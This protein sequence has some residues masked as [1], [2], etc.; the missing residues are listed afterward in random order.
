MKNFLK[1]VR[2][3]RVLGIAAVVLAL[4]IPTA[5]GGSQVSP[6][7]VRR[8]NEAVAGVLSG[9]GSNPGTIAPGLAE[10]GSPGA[11]PTNSSG[12]PALPG[13]A[14]GA[15][16]TKPGAV[17]GTGSGSPPI[18]VPKGSCTGFKN[19]QGISDSTIKIGNSSDVSGPVPGLFKAAQQATKAYVAYFNSTSSICGR[20]LDLMNLDSRTDAGADQV[21]YN[22]L[23]A[24][25]FA[26][27]GSMSAF[28]SGGAATAQSCGLP[29]IRTAP[30]TGDRANCST[31]FGT[32]PL[33]T[34]REFQNSVY[35]YW[36]SRDRPSTQKS[37][38]LYLNAGAAAEQAKIQKNAGEKLGMKWLY[39]S[40]IDVAD[41]NYSP[42]VQQMKS[43]GVEFVQFLGAYQ[44][45]AR[46]AIAMKQN[47][48]TPK[49]R[50][51]DP[52]IYEPGFIE[53][54]GA[55]AEGVI[56]FINFQPLEGNQKEL[57]LYKS[58]LQQV[59][60]GAKPTFFGLF[61][62]SSAKL[63]VEKSIALGGK[64]NRANLVSA[65]KA[66]HSWEGGG[67]HPKVDVGAKLPPAC[68][69]MMT[70]KNGS[71]VP[72]GSTRFSCGGYTRG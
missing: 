26:A 46:L 13:S 32:Q 1:P 56:F 25:T 10:P 40:P 41:F 9:S 72:Y 33:S 34:N 47:G 20:K 35:E 23:C 63:F 2:D 57:A 12:D 52:S 43:K 64:L 18:A 14:V 71:F 17:G 54:A 31:C 48:F 42:Y 62:W 70:I 19:G 29:D 45:S 4:A 61:A 6:E 38:F 53:Q 67:M 8:A 49:Y 5:C 36:L 27:V 16:G 21:A 15:S 3:R 7:E 68:V 44:Q 58:W 22:K 66:T 55:S 69:R 37:A 24:Q 59:D 60:P 39:V 51:Y 28:D 50:F 11:A 30:V 65:I